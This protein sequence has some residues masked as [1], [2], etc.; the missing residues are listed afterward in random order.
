MSSAEEDAMLNAYLDILYPK[1][2]VNYSK[3]K[4]F[5]PKV[6]GDSR[7]LDCVYN[8]G[9][10][11]KDLWQG[12]FQNTVFPAIEQPDHTLES[13]KWEKKDIPNA[14]DVEKFPPM[15]KGWLI[16]NHMAWMAWGPYEMLWKSPY[17]IRTPEVGGMIYGKNSMEKDASKLPGAIKDG[18]KYVEVTSS[19]P[20][21]C[22]DSCGT[23]YN[24]VRGSGMFMEVGD[25]VKIMVTRNKISAV[26]ELYA[27]LNSSLSEEEA[28]KEALGKIITKQTKDNKVDFGS[29]YWSIKKNDVMVPR[30]SGDIAV[31]ISAKVGQK[32]TLAQL[33]EK[34]AYND[35]GK[36]IIEWLGNVPV[37]DRI[38]CDLAYQLDLNL[39]QMVVAQYFGFWANEFVW[40]D[41]YMDQTMDEFAALKLLTVRGDCDKNST[42][43]Y[44]KDKTV[45][46]L[47]CNW[48]GIDISGTDRM[49]DL[50]FYDEG[51]TSFWG[52]FLYVL[53][54]IGLLVLVIFL[55]KRFLLNKYK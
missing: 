20:N 22:C 25:F 1:D 8:L 46:A 5:I 12:W 52:I 3:L 15:E 9:N 41:Q 34:I 24:A 47:V 14:N 19:L 4:D 45:G 35:T 27:K 39:V 54:I 7:I 29:W 53:I 28:K 38:I 11:N 55:L 13:W 51:G 48:F 49:D 30:S 50:Y 40:L 2:G 32:L 10:T 17:D 21:P 36:P 6:D 43:Y 33:L 23:W 26:I 37:V 31:K 16:P 18:D 44:D 42:V